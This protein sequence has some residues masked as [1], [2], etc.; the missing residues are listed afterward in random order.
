MKIKSIAVLSTAAIMIL[1]GCSQPQVK[2]TTEEPQHLVVNPSIVSTAQKKAAQDD[3]TI[4]LDN[5]TNSKANIILENRGDKTLKLDNISF[6]DA[7]GLF[8][9]KNSCPKELAAHKQCKLFVEFTGQNKGSYSAKIEITSNDP[10]KKVTRIALKADALDKYHGKVKKIESSKKKMQ[11]PVKLEFNALNTKQLVEIK[12]DGLD[13]LKLQPPKLIGPDSSSFSYNIKCPKILKIGESCEVTVNYDPK[14]KEGYSDALLFIPSN[15]T[16]TPSDAIQLTGYSKPYSV[17]LKDFVVQKNI[18][19]FL[20]DYF[21]SSKTYYFRTIY[22]GDVDRLLQRNIENEIKQ[23]FQANGFRMA[24]SADKADRIIT[25]YP[26]ITAQREEKT[27]DISYDITMAGFV[28]TKTKYT[29]DAG[30][31]IGFDVNTNAAEFSV[32]SP[33]KLFSDKEQF[34]FG[35]NIQVDN[36]SNDLEI[37]QTVSDIIVSKLFNVLGLK[38]TKGIK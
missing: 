1:A 4:R 12:N 7:T 34:I 10:R 14:K 35:M 3:Y 24:T 16:I 18:K 23:Y 28:T 6:K 38:D 29:K 36:A 19:N 31:K 27:N 33:K 22:Q 21:T 8:K 2:P 37:S 25:L 9:L 13:V 26:N 20:D 5:Y 15:G 30:T 17:T 32:L 11:Q